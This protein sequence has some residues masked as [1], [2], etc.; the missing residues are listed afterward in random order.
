MNDILEIIKSDKSLADL[1][2]SFSDFII[3]KEAQDSKDYLFYTKEPYT[4]FATDG[5]GGTFGFIGD[6]NSGAIGY[7]SSEG[8]SG[9]IADSLEELFKIIT[10]YPYFW[11]N[12]IRFYKVHEKDGLKKFIE[13]CE[14]EIKEDCPDYYDNQNQISKKL[15]IN[16]EDKLL[17]QLITALLDEPKFIVY[18]SEDDNP[19]DV[20]L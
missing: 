13:E 16:K 18:S 17:E 14:N 12:I 15:S 19:S 9:K 5:G 7:V 1:L 8:E 11:H 3:S 6:Y 20:L 4:I 10:Y 2:E